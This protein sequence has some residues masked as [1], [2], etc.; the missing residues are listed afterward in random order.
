MFEFDAVK[1]AGDVAQSIVTTAFV[2]VLAYFWGLR[3]ARRAAQKVRILF[4]SPS[5][6]TY[7]TQRS[8]R[9]DE[10]SRAELLG[11]AG[12]AVGGQAAG[13]ILPLP[14]QAEVDDVK[15]GRGDV[16]RLRF[17]DES[18]FVKACHAAEVVAGHAEPAKPAQKAVVPLATQTSVDEIRQEV[19]GLGTKLRKV[20]SLTA[21][22]EEVQ[23]LA[24]SVGSLA[25]EV[26]RVLEAVRAHTVLLDRQRPLPVLD[27]LD[28]QRVGAR[29]NGR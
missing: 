15:A 20:A 12:A 11:Q 27:R 24:G 4:V 10:V 7:D 26:G 19:E 5:G 8:P 1:I 16:V 17:V 9:R 3:A 21:T 29:R 22:R 28:P 2:A 23:A 18:M 25:G 13:V 6:E 14:N